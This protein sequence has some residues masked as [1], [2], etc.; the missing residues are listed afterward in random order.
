[1]LLLP[2]HDL[3]NF[4]RSLAREKKAKARGGVIL[5]LPPLAHFVLFTGHT[6]NFFFT[7]QRFGWFPV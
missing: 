2:L 3:P 7:P 4:R 6:P 5:F 1:M